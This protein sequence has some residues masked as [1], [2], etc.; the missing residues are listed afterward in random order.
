MKIHT[1]GG[2]HLR[3]AQAAQR[4]GGQGIGSG[5]VDAEIWRMR[6]RRVDY[7]VYITDARGIVVF[8]SSGRA[9]GQDYSRW[10]DVYLTLRGRYGARSS[11][12]SVLLNGPS[13]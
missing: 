8:D 12:A 9:L 3:Q 5:A 13:K 6:K 11:K 10:N 1:P 7:R 2:I 4:G